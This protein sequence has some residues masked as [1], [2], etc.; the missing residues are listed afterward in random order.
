MG[1]ESN[2]EIVARRLPRKRRIIRAVRHRPMLPSL[3]TFF[4]AIFTKTD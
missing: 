3:I 2:T 1:M 4:T